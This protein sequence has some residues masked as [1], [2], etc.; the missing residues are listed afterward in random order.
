MDGSSNIADAL[1][2]FVDV[3]GISAHLRSTGQ[4]VAHGRHAIMPEVVAEAYC[5]LQD[6]VQGVSGS[7]AGVSGQTAGISGMFRM[8]WVYGHKG[9]F[10]LRPGSNSERPRARGTAAEGGCSDEHPSAA[11]SALGRR[12]PDRLSCC[13]PPR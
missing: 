5:V 10:E 12:T 4:F 11:I 8:P 1:T 7:T 2:K 9:P 6:G 13:A 3:A